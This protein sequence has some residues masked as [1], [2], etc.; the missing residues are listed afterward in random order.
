M[1]AIFKSR[2][3]TLLWVGQLISVSGDWL[4]TIAVPFFVY[5]LTGSLL[6]TGLT[7]MVE[8]LPR[9]LVGPLAGVFVDRWNRRSTMLMIDLLRALVLCL[10]FFVHNSS[11]VPLIYVAM[12]LQATLSQFFTPASNALLPNIVDREHLVTA[13]SAMSLNEALTRLIGPPI[14]GFLLALLGLTGMVIVDSLTYLFSACMIWLIV[15]P[16][17]LNRSPNSPLSFHENVVEVGHEWMTGLRLI[18]EKPLL[19]GIFVIA[20][21]VMFA[22]GILNAILVV[23]TKQYMHQG[24]VAY[25]WMITSQ[26]IGSFIGA[27]LI[28]TLGKRVQPDYIVATALGV[29]GIALLCIANYPVLALAL[30]LLAIAG[31]FVVGFLIIIQSLLQSEVADNYRGRI[32]ALFETILAGGMLCGMLCASLLG[33]HL[34]VIPLFDASAILTILASPLSFVVLHKVKQISLPQDQSSG[35][36]SVST[37]STIA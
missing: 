23:F 34:G 11:T 10:L 26:G 37:T 16:Q 20:V 5:Q 25:G 21:F 22:Q 8:L 24:A 7:Y 15:T 32:M 27:I 30:V 36:A 9:L 13:N 19:K 28:G 29:C 2:N 18:T 6:Q 31:V 1:V 3:F 12:F 14:G 17:S 35:N 33:D 4:L